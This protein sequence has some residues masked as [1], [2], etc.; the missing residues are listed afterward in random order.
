[1]KNKYYSEKPLIFSEKSDLIPLP[2]CLDVPPI[3]A[4]RLFIPKRDMKFS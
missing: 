4:G 2:P 1:V 3:Q